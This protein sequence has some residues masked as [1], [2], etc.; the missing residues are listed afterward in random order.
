MC[1]VTLLIKGIAIGRAYSND[2]P[3][4]LRS[5]QPQFAG[6]AFWQER[7]YERTEKEGEQGRE[8]GSQRG[9]N[10]SWWKEL[11]EC[12][13]GRQVRSDVD[14]NRDG[15]TRWRRQHNRNNPTDKSNLLQVQSVEKLRLKFNMVRNQ[16]SLSPAAYGKA[17][18]TCQ[19]SHFRIKTL[20]YRSQKGY[21]CVLLCAVSAG[22]CRGGDEL[23]RGPKQMLRW[24]E[25]IWAWHSLSWYMIYE[26]PCFVE[27]CRQI[28]F[29]SRTLKTRT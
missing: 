27:N 12:W 15:Q 20:S 13:P 18:L 2:G 4:M 9:A 8:Q 23:L 29:E 11:E 10:G 19:S 25:M 5:W 14:E 22:L 21:L 16:N 3:L 28:P 24:F 6:K 1:V 26:S 17:R 7:N